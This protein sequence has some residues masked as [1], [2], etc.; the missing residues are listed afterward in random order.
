M[1]SLASTVLIAL[2]TGRLSGVTLINAGQREYG[3]N[4]GRSD[5]QRSAINKVCDSEGLTAV[6]LEGVV[7]T[8]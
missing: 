2:F 5:E 6:E 3:A 4:A 8:E 1:R 7:T